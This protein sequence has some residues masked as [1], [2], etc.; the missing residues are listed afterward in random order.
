MRLAKILIAFVVLALP[1]TSSAVT[2]MVWVGCGCEHNGSQFDQVCEADATAFPASSTTAIK[3]DWSVSSGGIIYGG[4]GEDD[5][6]ASADCVSQANC[7]LTVSVKVKSVNTS[8]I[9]TATGEYCVL[10]TSNTKQC[11]FGTSTGGQ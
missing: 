3:Y 1:M 5:I 4:G 11:A 10:A 9:D 2:P 7:S 6:V 8:C